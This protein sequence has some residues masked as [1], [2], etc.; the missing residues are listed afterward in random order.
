MRHTPN[1]LRLPPATPPLTD[2]FYILFLTELPPPAFAA[3]FPDKFL[4]NFLRNPVTFCR[5]FLHGQLNDITHDGIHF[6]EMR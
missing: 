4:L 2:L 3:F 6:R 1:L 5:F